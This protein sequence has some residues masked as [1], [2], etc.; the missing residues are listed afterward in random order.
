MSG[1]D[2]VRG[3]G[4][5]ECHTACR[6]LDPAVRCR[7]GNDLQLLSSGEEYVPGMLA[8]IDRARKSVDLELY[9]VDPGDLWELFRVALSK[10]AARGVEV[11]LLADS[12]GSRRMSAA[13]WRAARVG[14]VRVRLTDSVL[15]S[16][17]LERSTGRD[18]RKLLVVDKT[19]AFTGGMSIDDTFFR[20]RGEPT[21]RE[22]MVIVRGPVAAQMQ[23]AFDM[24]WSRKSAKTLV[25]SDDVV[26]ET[27]GLR[28][29]RLVLSSRLL[30]R[31]EGLFL[32][33]I[34]GAT[35]S[36]FITNPFVVPSAEIVHALIAAV[37]R[38]VDVRLLVPGQY[39]R[40]ALVRDAMRGFYDE[41]L[42]R[43]VRILEYQAAMLHAK[44]IVVDETWASVGSFNLDARS[45]VFNDELAV[46]ACD[47]VFAQEVS[48]AF[49]TDCDA[50]VEVGRTWRKRSDVRWGR[51]S[52]VRF[53]RSYL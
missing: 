42:R 8:A 18:H 24:S 33:A 36:V 4:G 34:S 50:A 43:G 32:A 2:R 1:I 11:R 25:N 13:D 39:H 27:A 19:L 47:R 37:D 26:S 30:P 9:R 23:C 15:M 41:L 38:S 46:A 40:F 31:G 7:G 22:S 44:T 35:S 20:P 29:A 3:G 28:N 10:A 14:G 6:L 12:F 51:E 52:L 45:F 48:D 17:L 49:K 21:W 5:L 16:L 53:L